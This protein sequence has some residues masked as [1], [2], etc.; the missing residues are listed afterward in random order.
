MALDSVQSGV[1]VN[2]QRRRDSHGHGYFP[3]LGLESSQGAVDEDC[4]YVKA[5]EIETL[6]QRDV[7]QA[8]RWLE[9]QHLGISV[10][11]SVFCSLTSP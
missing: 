4:P 10:V 5:A 2:S 3:I 1:V 8:R 6:R 7:V 11:V 9:L